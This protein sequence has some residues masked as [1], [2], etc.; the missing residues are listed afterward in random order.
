[1]SVA[2]FMFWGQVFFLAFFV[3]ING[4]YILLNLTAAISLRRYRDANALSTLPELY[5]GLE[6]PVSLLVPARLM[7]PGSAWMVSAHSS[8][9]L[10]LL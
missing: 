2:D 6:P 8:A 3:G 7:V 9:W 5:S 1:M 10:P 4:C